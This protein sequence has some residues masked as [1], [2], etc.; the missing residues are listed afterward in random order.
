MARRNSTIAESK[1]PALTAEQSAEFRAELQ[2]SVPGLVEQVDSMTLPE[3]LPENPERAHPLDLKHNIAGVSLEHLL[4]E[5]V[6]KMRLPSVASA[7]QSLEWGRKVAKARCE[8]GKLKSKANKVGDSTH[9]LRNK[10][11]VLV[12]GIT[13]DVS[14]LPEADI[15]EL[16]RLT[17]ITKAA[18]RLES[19]R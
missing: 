18:E 17:A 15:K 7:M 9:S 10:R 11:T 12:E 4:K 6:V 16:A 3:T 14:N 5:I 1:V 2:K 19:A 13:H 8:I